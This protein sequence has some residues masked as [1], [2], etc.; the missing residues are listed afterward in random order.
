MEEFAKRARE[1]GAPFICV[2]GP[3]TWDVRLGADAAC[4][5]RWEVAMERSWDIVMREPV[6]AGTF[7]WEWQ[8]RAVSD[9]SPEKL[10]YWFPETGIN[11]LKIKGVVDGFRDPGPRHYNLK[12]VYS[13]IRVGE[14]ADVSEATASFDVGNAYSFTNLS[15]LKLSWQLMRDG[16]MIAKGDAKADVAPLKN[17]ESS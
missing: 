17:A 12:M 3:N 4:L 14:K 7:L 6:L 10:Y 8:D 15:D 1:T 9:K 5:D 13:P 11:L 2:E 16:K